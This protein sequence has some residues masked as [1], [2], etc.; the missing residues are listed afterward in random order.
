[1][2]N[3]P[4]AP[5]GLA[6]R[7]TSLDAFRGFV[8]LSMLLGTLGLEKLSGTPVLGFLYTQLNHVPWVGFH[9]E[10]LILPAFLFIIGVSMA[11]SDEKRRR[12]GQSARRRFLHAF[13]RSVLLFALGFLL[14]WLGSGKPYWGAGVLQVLALSYLGGFLFLGLSIRARFAV[15]GALL[16]IY[17]LFIFIIP[18]YGVGRN[19][20]EVFKNLVFTIDNAVTGE[21]TRWGYLYTIITSIGVVVYGSIIGKLLINRSDH[22]RF[23]KT[24]AILGGIGVVAGLVLHPFVPIIK[25]MFTSSYTLFTCG[26]AT[27]LLL[28]FTWLIDVREHKSWSFV[29]VVLGMNSIFVYLL[30]GLLST[31]LM[32]A[33]GILMGPVAG[34]MGAW[35]DPARNI[36][37]LFVEWLVC[38]W[39]FRKKIFIRL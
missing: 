3:T 16:I 33:G 1:M 20:Y 4:G 11:I 14:S 29:F 7:I 17:W 6:Q 18:V 39:L 34:A 5:P 12:C 15:F 28:G 27:L 23:M 37:R 25:R 21:A 26:L 13:E 35:I 32:D 19:S 8:M 22:R 31:W 36:F 10:D 9:F 2:S 30:N 24:L 38:L